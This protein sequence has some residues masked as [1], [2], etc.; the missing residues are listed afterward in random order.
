MLLR[1]LYALCFLPVALGAQ[2][3]FVTTTALFG[4]LRARQ[5]GPAVMSGRV[6][7]LAVDPTDATVIYVGAAGGGVWKTTSGGATIQ[8]VFDDHTQS[9]GAIAVAPSQPRTVYVGT[10]EPWPRNTVSVGTGMYRSDDGG[11]S[12]A[13]AG[14]TETE[15]IADVAIHPEDP[16][17]IWVAALGHLWDSHPERGV[18]KSTDGGRSYRKVLYLDEDTGAANLKIDPTDPDVLYAAMWSHRRTPWSFDSGLHGKSGLYKSTDGGENWALLSQG[19]PE[20]KLG[21][22]GVAPAHD[23][24]TV[25]AS[26]ETGAE[27][28]KGIYRSTDAG[29]T[30]AKAGNNFNAGVRPFYFSELTVDPSD[31]GVVAKCGLNGIISE[32][33]GK[34]W[35]IFDGRVHSDFHDIWID[36]NNGKHILVATDGGVYESVDRGNTFRMWM[37]LPISQFYHVSVDNADPYRVYG[38]LQDNGSWYAVNSKS[39]GVSNADWKKTFGGDGFYS[40][41]H[42]TKDHLVFSEFQGGSI[43]RYDER[44][45]RSKSIN[46]YTEAGEP[47]LRFNWNSPLTMSADGKRLYFA[48]QHLYRS[49]DDGDSYEKISPDLTTDDPEK[50]QQAKSGGLS[51]DNSTAENHTTIYAVAE[52]PLDERTIWV[53]TDDGNLQLTHDGGAN[54]KKLNDRL[55]GLPENTWVTYVEPSPHDRGTAFVTF[56]GHR[57]GDLTPYLY[58]TTDGGKTW[59]SITDENIS[60]YALSVRQ[61]LVNPNLLF[62]GTEFGLYISLD[63]G[64]S[65][66]PFRNNVPQVGIRD[67]VIHPR[68]GDLVLATHGRG[69]IILD[70]LEALRQITADV[71]TRAFTFLDP[72]TNTLPAGDG[73][74]NGDFS[75]SGNFV[76][77]AKRSAPRVIFYSKKRHLFGKMYAELWKDGELLRT[78]PAGKGAGINV[79]YLPLSREKPKAA[80]SNNRGAL[81]GSMT[82]PNLPPGTYQVK[83]TKGKETY[84]TELAIGVEADDVYTAAD[85][86]AQTDLLTQVYDDTEK[87]AWVYEV[88]NQVKQQTKMLIDGDGAQVPGN[89]VKSREQNISPELK[90]QA[91]ALNET[92]G[93]M[94][95]G[96][97]FLG[98]DFYVN[99]ESRLREDIGKLYFAISTFPG[100]PSASQRGEA[101]RVHAEL[102]GVVASFDTLL[103][104]EVAPLNRALP[105]AMRLSWPSQEQFLSKDDGGATT[106]SDRRY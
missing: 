37:N 79:L 81:F 7:C 87:L 35:R 68:D 85:R 17:T 71:T 55:P 86:K 11:Q 99:E 10:G 101:E 21:R 1:I 46:L 94:M 2:G 43:I 52:S 19:L 51:I 15:R 6:S 82:G 36:P 76:G 47:A 103:E 88:L 95:S 31:P 53:G 63:G 32:D 12:W 77:P 49:T 27:G 62:L 18:Y 56:D 26:V 45:G 90:K 75:G 25:Y 96:L 92:V 67:M 4:N 98:G 84:E 59:E 39:G 54:W 70:D 44:T 57:T 97:V 42:P 30:W 38:G 100:Q 102:A 22:I 5:I 48:A 72:G 91:A 104:D 50:Q 93:K 61:D 16:N 69:I 74:S 41:R 106:D 9:I 24:K 80:P 23:G 14:L 65:W 89:D 83:I 73:I 66:A 105:E 34:T 78:L 28:T 40:F 8:P 29:A 20:E 3:D 33:G 13:S 64:A 60:G 58:R